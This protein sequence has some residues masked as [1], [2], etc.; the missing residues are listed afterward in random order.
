M[1]VEADFF[2]GA[3]GEVDNAVA[4]VGSAVVDATF[5]GFAVFE[6]G[7]FDDAGERK[8]LVGGDFVP[9]HDF[10]ADGGV[11]AFEAEEFGFVEPRGGAD[12]GVMDGFI[13]THRVVGLTTDGVGGALVVI[14]VSAR[15]GAGNDGEGKEGGQEFRHG[16]NL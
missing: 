8:G 14:V 2:G 16:A 7:D 9:R 11:A 4:D 15:V 13:D 3:G 5:D 6:V 10:F 1:V 12:V